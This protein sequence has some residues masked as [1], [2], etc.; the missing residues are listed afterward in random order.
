MP[1]LSRFS[2][3]S[4]KRKDVPTKRSTVPT[5]TDSSNPKSY[6]ALDL[7]SSS[8][9][10]DESLAVPFG[11]TSTSDAVSNSRTDLESDRNVD[12]TPWIDVARET[13]TDS[14][15]KPLLR[16]L[17]RIDDPVRSRR[18][19]V[20]LEKSRIQIDQ[21]I[22]LVDECSQ[23][24]RTRGLTTL[25]IF[26]PFRS[27]E[28][29]V[30]I[31]LVA[32]LYLDYVSEFEPLPPTVASISSTRG[33]QANKTVKLHRFRE[34]LRYTDI[35][36]VVAVLKWGLRHFESTT[37]FAFETTTNPRNPF[38]FYQT[39]LDQTVRHSFP[40]TS[41]TDFLVPLLT[42]PGHDLIVSIL[43][44]VQAVAA[45]SESNAM[46]SSRLCRTIGIYLFQLPR[47]PEPTSQ[48]DHEE[49]GGRWNELYETWNQA[50]TVLE[51]LLKARIR[52]QRDLPP[53]LQELA[54]G[55]EQFVYEEQVRFRKT[56]GTRTE[57]N[58]TASTST[59]TTARSRRIKVLTVSI[60]SR[61]D[62]WK[63]VGEEEQDVARVNDQE[64]GYLRGETM[65]KSKKYARRKPASILQDAF[66][67]RFVPIDS[68]SSS[69]EAL[70]LWNSVKETGARQ[71]LREVVDSET[72]RI[73]DLLGLLSLTK[74]NSTQDLGSDIFTTSSPRRRQTSGPLTS[75]YEQGHLDSGNRLGNFPNKSVAHLANE[76]TKDQDPEKK[77]IVTRNWNDFAQ[78]GFS[79]LAPVGMLDEFGHINNNNNSIRDGEKEGDSGLDN[80]RPPRQ[81]PSKIVK[82]DLSTEIDGEFV[83]F[84]LDTLM[85]TTTTLSPVSSWPSFVLVPLRSDL[86]PASSP[87]NPLH[88]LVH[89]QL[90]PLVDSPINLP[91][92][93][94]LLLQRNSSKR[95]ESNTS[96][97][98]RKWTKRASSIF[99][100]GGGGGNKREV[101]SESTYTLNGTAGSKP[102]RSP[103]KSTT[104]TRELP[105]P[106]PIVPI[107][108]TDER[109]PS[110]II[111]PY[112]VS[113]P[114]EGNVIT[115]TLSR[116]IGRRKSKS[117]VVMSSPESRD[118]RSLPPLPS[119]E[120][121]RVPQFEADS[122]EPLPAIP[123]KYTL[124]VE[125]AKRKN[126]ASPTSTTTALPKEAVAE[127]DE[128]EKE[129]KL[130]TQQVSNSART[131]SI[132]LPPTPSPPPTKSL[133]LP[134]TVPVET[135]LKDV[136][137]EGQP[138]FMA[139]PQDLSPETASAIPLADSP[140]IS[141]AAV[142]R[143][144]S[145][146]VSSMILTSTK[147]RT[148]EDHA[149]E[150]TERKDVEELLKTPEPVLKPLEAISSPTFTLS[151]PGG[152]PEELS[153]AEEGEFGNETVESREFDAAVGTTDQS[154]Q[155]LGLSN[156]DEPSFVPITEDTAQPAS[157]TKLATPESSA[158]FNTTVIP[159]SPTIPPSPTPSSTSQASSSSK[160]FL[161]KTRSFLSRKKSGSALDKEKDKSPKPVEAK[162]DKDLRHLQDQD[163]TRNSAK[164]EPS[165][166]LPPTPVSSVKKR[167]AELE[168]AANAQTFPPSPTT[169]SRL[170]KNVVTTSPAPDSPTP[171]PRPL[172]VASSIIPL[173]PT[174][175]LGN[176]EPTEAKEVAV[177]DSLATTPE[178]A[179]QE[180]R[181]DE[182]DTELGL[183]TVHD[184]Q[185]AQEEK[186]DSAAE[187]ET[188]TEEPHSVV[189]EEETLM[190]TDTL[191]SSS[192][193]R[194]PVQESLSAMAI[195]EDA[196]NHEPREPEH[197]E[198]E[199]TPIG[200]EDLQQ[201][202][203][204]RTLSESTTEE[205]PHASS[206]GF[207]QPPEQES[208]GEL[209]NAEMMVEQPA[210]IPENEESYAADVELDS[211]SRKEEERSTGDERALASGPV[212][213]TIHDAA[214]IK[215]AE[216]EDEAANAPDSE[217]LD[218]TDTASP[219]IPMQEAQHLEVKVPSSLE[220]LPTPI[221]S[222]SPYASEQ[223]VAILV[224][225]TR[226][227]DVQDSDLT[228]PSDAETDLVQAHEREAS[229][230]TVVPEESAS[231]ANGVPPTTPSKP[232]FVHSSS[233]TTPIA[234]SAALFGSSISPS[235][236]NSNHEDP[237][238]D[239]TP[240]KPSLV[241]ETDA[242]LIPAAL[243]ESGS[244]R[245]L[246]TKNSQD[247]FETAAVASTLASA[248]SSLHAHEPE[249]S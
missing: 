116:T 206:S 84:W 98:P 94:P 77:R 91:S 11:I 54:Q 150:G 161:A 248:A 97:N 134:P 7:P 69:E 50:G 28:N 23:V 67:A 136:L 183:S 220:D 108:S 249:Q 186:P 199:T 61:S 119:P 228:E 95:I 112:S 82:V 139:G 55:F 71:G 53:R 127:L 15:I 32:L 234:S 163:G 64:T 21:M 22:T 113:P 100:G 30:Q 169:A 74:S 160:K 240:I 167:V 205:N 73:F 5:T 168:A 59:I 70:Q 170:G 1:F 18:D 45:Y 137:L 230:V 104:A 106:V 204:Q 78:T 130:E 164:K 35:H 233:M 14:P 63:L 103:R 124:E 181:A 36:N 203:A 12:T 120:H 221:P 102:S 48:S 157:Q 211:S 9:W 25:G 26:R 244:N 66:K 209:A 65:G 207:D 210:N 110:T 159:D 245:S 235:T 143:T 151:P 213:E 175:E 223:P 144:P 218:Q 149:K 156:L 96:L 138:M 105:P 68:D 182:E 88:L 131:G 146:E 111:E 72:G 194:N 158:R 17:D 153:T 58:S 142:M 128:E 174:E 31:R 118:D 185:Y 217:T 197:A 247:T 60:E 83:D 189:E 43:D 227:E 40:I 224:D 208:N 147:E 155:G 117:S 123:A 129:G 57:P 201:L 229:T 200:Q 44:L 188:L 173:P 89:D 86:T 115:R 184:S 177:N 178:Q 29:L 238:I 3:S 114:T 37:P 226:V 125:E 16:G 62:Q 80:D 216:V 85:E 39:F 152:E 52:E 165:K 239:S 135:P 24:I 219:Q 101:S 140:T 92:P 236:S 202:E 90:L 87:S 99:G 122:N 180:I 79:T 232:D 148:I 222:P 8:L 42:R 190:T 237:F 51:G 191:L 243:V 195:S 109:R 172:S 231:P 6:L 93:P 75:L 132:T 241:D 246:S 242:S 214:K 2:A 107:S 27:S 212:Q 10:R 47:T 162:K 187:A 225:E 46:N 20:K 76:S 196:E 171:Q 34:E 38:E 193:R 41:F 176:P 145:S 121:E 13:G 33:T 133:P 56:T 126:R 81:E 154:P 166:R 141:R 192:E 19:W 215:H 198:P 49:Q 179:T 4:S